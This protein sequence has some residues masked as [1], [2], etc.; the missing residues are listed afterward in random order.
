MEGNTYFILSQ[1]WLNINAIIYI[2]VKEQI[3]WGH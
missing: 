3:H 2:Y 1:D